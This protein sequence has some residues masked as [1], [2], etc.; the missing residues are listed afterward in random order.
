MHMLKTTSHLHNQVR[1]DSLRLKMPNLDA[2]GMF[3]SALCLVHCLVLPFVFMLLP[4]LGSHFVHDDRTHYCLAF[5]VTAFCL[6]AVVPGYL[7]HSN[8]RVLISMAIGLSLV[9]FGT[10][11]TTI[12]GERWELP[13]IT[14]GN[15]LVVLAHFLNRRLLATCCD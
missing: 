5:F 6:T 8:K 11:A 14:V 7:R 1:N 4:T 12:T 2:L 15:V 13:L 3:A 10:F 9:L